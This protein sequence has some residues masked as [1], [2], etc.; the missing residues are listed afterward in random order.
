MTLW[1][2][3][4]LSNFSKQTVSGS[5][6]TWY[7]AREKSA[8]YVIS[9]Q[10][11]VKSSTYRCLKFHLGSIVLGSLIRP[12]LIIPQAIIKPIYKRTMRINTPLT[13]C[14]RKL[15]KA[16]YC[17]KWYYTWMRYYTKRTFIMVNFT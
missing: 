2:Y 8:L 10:S 17:I 11:P 16:C 9:I 7:F 3:S 14:K 1:L 12:L 6:A 5:V 15:I 4:F 13:S